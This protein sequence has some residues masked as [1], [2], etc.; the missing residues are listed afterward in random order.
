[1]PDFDSSRD[2]VASAVASWARVQASF[3]DLDTAIAAL[4]RVGAGFLVNLQIL[5]F[6]V[7]GVAVF[8]VMAF[9]LARAASGWAIAIALMPLAVCGACVW[10]ATGYATML[11]RGT[12]KR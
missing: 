6:S 4:P 5:A 12:T 1:M 11:A 9:V 3:F 7:V 10:Y 2:A 8:G